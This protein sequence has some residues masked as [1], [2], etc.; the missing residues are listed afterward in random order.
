MESSH[1]LGRASGLGPLNGSDG[2]RYSGGAMA[3]LVVS[4]MAFSVV[5]AS[6][7]HPDR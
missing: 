3:A 2:P 7:D 4:V 6:G 5:E 1:G